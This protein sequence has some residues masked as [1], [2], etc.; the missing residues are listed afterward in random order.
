MAGRWQYKVWKVEHI[1]GHFLKMAKIFLVILNILV[2]EM[3]Y[4]NEFL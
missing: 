2:A 1:K 3:D 4:Y